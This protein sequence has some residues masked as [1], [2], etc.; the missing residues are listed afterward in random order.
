MRMFLFHDATTGKEL[1]RKFQWRGDRGTADGNGSEI[2]DKNEK[3]RK[4]S[5]KLSAG[6]QKATLGSV[7]RQ[8]GSTGISLR[9]SPAG[10]TNPVRPN[11]QTPAGPGLQFTW[12]HR[13]QAKPP[14]NSYRFFGCRQPGFGW[15]FL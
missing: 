11:G 13:K 15:G 14:V 2:P 3:D 5:F 4:S 1:Y 6:G 12:F 7:Q 9:D 10:R 8:S